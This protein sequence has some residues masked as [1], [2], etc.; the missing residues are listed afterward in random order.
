MSIAEM[1][2]GEFE[3]ETK[4]TRRMLERYPTGKDDWKPHGKSFS[5]TGLAGHVTTLAN[6]ATTIASQDK[7][8]MKAGDYKPFYPKT[9]AEALERFE[10]ETG[11][12]R[13]AIAKLSDADMG[14]TWSFAYEGKELFAMPRIVAL[15]SFYFNHVVHHRGQ[16]TVYYRL[17]DVAVPGLYGPSADEPM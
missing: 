12:A 13:A 16:L 11:K 17:N 8:D 9:P 15:R 2:L 10:E 4:N 6:F 7:L 1:L 5:M 14:K 3:H